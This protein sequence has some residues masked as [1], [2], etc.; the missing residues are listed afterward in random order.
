MTEDATPLNEDHCLRDSEVALMDA[1]K[2]IIEIML[3]AGAKAEHFDKLF[4]SQQTQYEQ[5]GTMPRAVFVMQS[6]R[7]FANDAKRAAHREQVQLI[8][9]EPPQGQA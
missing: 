4:A 5:L 8:L 7:D 6:L 3:S 9:Q 2:S 1:F